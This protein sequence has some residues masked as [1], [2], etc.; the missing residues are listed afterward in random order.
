M[1][2]FNRVLSAAVLTAS[3]CSVGA[4]AEADC[5]LE[6]IF[7]FEVDHLIVNKNNEM[8]LYKRV[9]GRPCFLYSN[10]DFLGETLTSLR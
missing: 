3:L 9:D 8:I 1:K 10:I 6:P 7:S 4:F 5:S 2:L